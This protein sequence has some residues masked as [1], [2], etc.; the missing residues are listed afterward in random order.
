MAM[1]YYTLASLY[2][3]KGEPNKARNYLAQGR[4]Y[5]KDLF[6]KDSYRVLGMWL[7]AQTATYDDAYELSLFEDLKWLVGKIK[8]SSEFVRA[9]P[10]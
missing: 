3:I 6:L 1:W 2:D 8:S 5:K 9:I 10:R 4:R 7:N